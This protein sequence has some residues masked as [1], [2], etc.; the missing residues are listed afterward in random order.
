[1]TLKTIDA[2]GKWTEVVPKTIALRTS[3]EVS[4]GTPAAYTAVYP[5]TQAGD[6][7][8]IPV[9]PMDGSTRLSCPTPCVCTTVS[10]SSWAAR[11]TLTL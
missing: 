6:S 3:R 7:L 8:V 4:G 1:V 11:C 10:S 2:E 9:C 5:Y